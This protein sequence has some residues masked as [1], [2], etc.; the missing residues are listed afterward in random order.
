MKLEENIYRL[1]TSQELS[2]ES[3]AELLGVSRQSVSKWETGTSVPDLDKLIKLCDIF[4]VTLDEL[5][6]RAAPSESGVADTDD[7]SDNDDDGA[8]TKTAGAEPPT[9]S[10]AYSLPP[11]TYAPAPV[12]KISLG[13]RICGTIL[14]I[15]SIAALLAIPAFLTYKA[16]AD[17]ET[18]SSAPAAIV[19]A[20]PAAAGLICGIVCLT[21]RRHPVL[22][23]LLTVFV[24]YIIFVS[25]LLAT[26]KV[27]VDE[28]SSASPEIEA[29]SERVTSP[30]D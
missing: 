17:A 11:Y 9:T 15:A 10:E 28:S 21:V 14:I 4:G 13:R 22:V 25:L 6:G 23:C 12:R 2:Q 19:V 26:A 1:R 18:A 5:T 3:L 20:I 29:H 16:N 24:S 27:D 30:G 7:S 8:E